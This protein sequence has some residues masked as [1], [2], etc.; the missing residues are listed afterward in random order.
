MSRA[1]ILLADDHTLFREGLAGLIN[2]Q[3]D[4]QVVGMAAEGL[5]ALE[6]AR[7]LRPDL[8]VMDINMP[9]CNGLEATRL[10]RQEGIKTK[11]VIL[12]VHDEDGNLFE[13]IKAGASGYLLKN[14]QS[15]DFLRGLRD[16]LAGDAALTPKLAARLL[17]E[18]AQP[19]AP[20]PAAARES[21]GTEPD[22][23]ARETEVL[24]L[25]ATGAPDK[26]IAASLQISIYTVKSHV[27]S[28][29]SKLHAVNRR[30]AAKRAVRQQLIQDPRKPPHSTREN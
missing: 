24:S 17:D 28:I 27:R 21:S 29:L 20:P 22:L 30:Q 25:I 19:A 1:R 2:A 10:I 8:V 11:I 9:I 3:R 6:L 15:A 18:F 13:A 14:V 23:T 16:V 26:Q 4:L 7:S 5:E 12:T